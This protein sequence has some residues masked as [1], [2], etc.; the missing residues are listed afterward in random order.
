MLVMTLCAACADLQSEREP[1]GLAE[2]QGRDQAEPQVPWGVSVTQRLAYAFAESG[3]WSEG[4]RED[5]GPLDD[6]AVLEQAHPDQELRWSPCG[7]AHTLGMRAS[8]GFGGTSTSNFW[9]FNS[10]ETPPSELNFVLE[11][12]ACPD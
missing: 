6:F 7:T 3:G 1:E 8:V 12:R 9:L 2:R 5:V 4:R 11:R 10:D